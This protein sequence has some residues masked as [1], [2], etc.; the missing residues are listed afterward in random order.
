MSR[1][2]WLVILLLTTGGVSTIVG[3][4]RRDATG[5]GLGRLVPDVDRLIIDAP[6]GLR[7]AVPLTLR[8]IGDSPVT[9]MKVRSSCGC[10]LVQVPENAV[11]AAGASTRLQVSVQP[12][13]RATRKVS[14]ALETDSEIAKTVRIELEVNG[15][16]Q[17]PPLVLLAPQLVEITGTMPGTPVEQTVCVQTLERANGLHWVTGASVDDP[18][19]EVTLANT[20][21]TQAA[22]DA[23]RRTY[24]FVV[25][26]LTPESGHIPRTRSLT[27]TTGYAAS[28]PTPA[29]PVRALFQPA[30]VPMPGELL[31]RLR[32]SEGD[33]VVRVIFLR[34]HDGTPWRVID[35]QAD[36]SW[37]DVQIDPNQNPETSDAPPLR[38]ILLRVMASE[39]QHGIDYWSTAVTV[40]FDHPQL[41][42]LQIPVTVHRASE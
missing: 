31:V 12:L 13:R 9:I 5:R 27:L 23:V 20:T 26:V 10:A 14:V 1:W 29:I 32:A 24:C 6:D 40:N 3:L 2:S 21:D 16:K 18:Q 7:R 22:G 41:T 15:A 35:A 38:K 42:H 33:D 25:T 4:T 34:C 17:T 39:L 36:A 37:L 28:E 30:V 8:N 19:F 11:V